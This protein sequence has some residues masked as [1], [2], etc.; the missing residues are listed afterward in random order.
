M[1][2]HK[3]WCDAKYLLYLNHCKVIA[4]LL[5]IGKGG[6]IFLCC[7]VDLLKYC[8]MFFH[9]TDV[10]IRNVLF[11]RG[12]LCADLPLDIGLSAFSHLIVDKT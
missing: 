6:V 7:L 1:C 10:K 8:R 12:K 11:Y 9:L 5:R 3:V 4:S 2:I